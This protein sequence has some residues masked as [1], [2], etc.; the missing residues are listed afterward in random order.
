MRAFTLLPALALLAAAPL[1]ARSD[2]VPLSPK[3]EQ[4]LAGRTAGKPVSCIQLNRSNGTQL[5]DKT[6]LIY[7][8][9]RH[10]WYVNQPDGGRCI[11]LN[12]NRAITSS[13]STAQLCANDLI[14]VIDPSSGISFG[15]CG[16]G[17]FVPYTK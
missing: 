10:L 1:L 6:A 9:S 16:L 14:T 3:A 15:S 7:K 8:Q 4:A 17:E 11:S 2:A 5:V 13:T 12:P